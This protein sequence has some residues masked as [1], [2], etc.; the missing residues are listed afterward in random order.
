MYFPELEMNIEPNQTDEWYLTVDDL[1]DSI[2]EDS[3][4]DENENEYSIVFWV[5]YI[6]YAYRYEGDINFSIYDSNEKLIHVGKFQ[7]DQFHDVHLLR[8][9]SDKWNTLQERSVDDYNEDRAVCNA[10]Y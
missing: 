4:M 5:D 8:T 3:L 10:G 2:Y 7:P 1:K 6:D 9:V